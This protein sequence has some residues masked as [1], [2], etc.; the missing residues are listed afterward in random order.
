MGQI[1]ADIDEHLRIAV[2]QKIKASRG[3]TL[4]RVLEEALR[5]W[6]QSQ[7]GVSSKPSARD[8]GSILDDP[9]AEPDQL[10][11]SLQHLLASR[12]S[13]DIAVAEIVRFAL[14]RRTR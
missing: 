1:N 8:G 10:E 4:K 13:E 14:T 2:W 3:L 9:G 6:L 5:L 11:R 12:K 7:S